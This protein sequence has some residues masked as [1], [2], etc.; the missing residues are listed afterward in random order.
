VEQVRADQHRL[1]QQVIEPTIES[2]T[3][4]LLSVGFSLYSLSMP[5]IPVKDRWWKS[6]AEPDPRG[7]WYYLGSDVTPLDAA[8]IGMESMNHLYRNDAVNWSGIAPNDPTISERLGVCSVCNQWDHQNATKPIDIPIMP[9]SKKGTVS[10]RFYRHMWM[11]KPAGTPIAVM[12]R[13]LFD[14]VSEDFDDDILVGDVYIHGGD[15]IPDLVTVLDRVNLPRRCKYHKSLFEYPGMTGLMPCHGCGRVRG[16]GDD[17]PEYIYTPELPN[18]SPR[19]AWTDLLLS[20]ETFR[21]ANFL[22]RT[23]WKQ[24]TCRKL[25]EYNTMIDPFPYPSPMYWEEMVNAFSQRGIQFPQRRQNV[26]RSER[27]GEWIQRQIEI[28]GEESLLVDRGRP[29]GGIDPDTL[30]TMIFYLRVR[31]L[32]ENKV[33]ERIDHWDDDVLAQF[34]VEYHEATEGMPEYFP[35]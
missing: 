1:L 11:S 26:F 4:A 5:A 19:I 7:D 3:H 24:L 22:D 17:G 13:K 15:R 6:K 29:H 23:E 34:L 31:A 27:P 33:A 30:E 20:P 28:H 32:F 25:R 12:H 35:V 16:Y 14:I 8:W 2:K 9:T 18:R 10:P 21:K